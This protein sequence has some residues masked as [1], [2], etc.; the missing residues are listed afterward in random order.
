MQFNHE[1]RD[2]GDTALSIGPMQLA[3][4]L[5]GY[6]KRIVTVSRIPTGDDY[7]HQVFF[8]RL[9]LMEKEGASGL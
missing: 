8:E 6:I 2:T 4:V 1:G 9:G 5:V 7:F 3:Q